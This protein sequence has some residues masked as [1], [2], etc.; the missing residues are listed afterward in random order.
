MAV[1]SLTLCVP[2]PAPSSSSYFWI[3]GHYSNYASNMGWSDYHAASAPPRL[4]D[5][6]KPSSRNRHG[7]PKFLLYPSCIIPR[8]QT[9]KEQSISH[10]VVMDR[11]V[12]Q[13]M[14]TVNL[15]DV[16]YYGAQYL[17]LRCGLIHPLNRLHLFRYFH[18][19]GSWCWVA[20]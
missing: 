15:F 2:P 16:D 7:S 13:H 14:K 10:P 9:P 12:F 20:G 6:S 17:H 5:L 1:V 3:A 8:P 19:C 4:F 18:K 11:V